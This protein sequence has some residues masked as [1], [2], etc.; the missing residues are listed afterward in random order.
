MKRRNWKL[1]WLIAVGYALLLA[2]V[3]LLPSGT[4]PLSGW[5]TAISPTLQNAL[6]VP[7][8]AALVVLIAR[9]LGRPTP[10]QLG[11]AALACCA[12]GGLLECAQAAIPGR[13]GSVTDMLLNGLGA[14]VGLVAV[15]SAKDRIF[16]ARRSTTAAPGWQEQ[17]QKSQELVRRHYYDRGWRHP[18]RHFE[19]LLASL[20]DKSSVVLDV[21]C[22][23]EFAMA[24]FLCELAAEVHGVDPVAE[25]GA[26]KCCA[27]LTRSGAERL[28][29]R[30]ET[31]NV[32]A[33]RC[34]LEHL[35]VPVRAVHEFRR[36]LKPDGRIVFLTPNRYDYVSLVAMAVPNALHGRIMGALEGREESDTFPTYYRANSARQIRRIARRARLHVERLEYLNHYPYLFTFSSLLFRIVTAYD[37]I[38]GR[39]RSLHGLQG[40][41]IGTLRKPTNDEDWVT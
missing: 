37:R 23:R 27:F 9:A 16:V 10:L 14:V 19:D 32:V 35:Q 34:V 30:D 8:Y 11:L 26:A 40:W 41:L 2:A 33:S 31:F 6:H 22:G 5:D 4:G 17:H 15:S 24:P 7:A 3:S 12:F 28:P 18:Y 20:L 21:G 29:Y 13:F 39:F 1:V 25:P 38:I 36:V